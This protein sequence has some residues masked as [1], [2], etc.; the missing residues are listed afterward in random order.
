MQPSPTAE[1]IG[2][3][4]PSFRCFICRLSCRAKSRHLSSLNSKRFL[5][6]ANAPLEMTRRSNLSNPRRGRV[7]FPALSDCVELCV[8]HRPG[9]QQ[10]GIFLPTLRFGCA[11][12]RSVHTGHTQSEAQRDAD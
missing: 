5:D 12:D 1:T 2:P 4:R 3:P 11:N 8:A 6:S 7:F 9:L 10:F